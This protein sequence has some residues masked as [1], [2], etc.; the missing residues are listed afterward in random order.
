M[1][2]YKDTRETIPMHQIAPYRDSSR[3]YIYPSLVVMIHLIFFHDHVV[4]YAPY[5]TPST[6]ICHIVMP[7]HVWRASSAGPSGNSYSRCVPPS[8]GHPICPHTHEIIFYH[9]PPSNIVINLGIGGPKNS[10]ALY[11]MVRTVAYVKDG[12]HP[13]T[14]IHFQLRPLEGRK[15]RFIASPLTAIRSRTHGASRTHRARV[16]IPHCCAVTVLVRRPIY[17]SP[18]LAHE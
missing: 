1:I 13:P 3:R 15:C 17:H 7:Y 11:D 10:H 6:T 8:R 2:E 16:G 12:Y 9:Y 4:G 14:A 18:L 5:A